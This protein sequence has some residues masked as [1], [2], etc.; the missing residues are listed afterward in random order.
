MFADPPSVV[1]IGGGQ[2]VEGG[3]GAAAVVLADCVEVSSPSPGSSRA[4]CELREE[5]ALI[6]VVLPLA[7]PDVV[8]DP[9][10]LGLAVVADPVVV[11]VPLLVADGDV[12][13]DAEV[14]DGDDVAA[15]RESDPT[16]VLAPVVW[17]SAAVWAWAAVMPSRM[18]AI[19]IVRCIACSLKKR[20][21]KAAP[22]ACDARQRPI[23]RK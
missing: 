4:A 8:T 11:V 9:L 21:A 2:M 3:L 16:A 23:Q 19:R 10:T 5:G 6:E 18:I 7:G 20:P 14:D 15:P 1:G 12:A 13:D 17:P 22:F